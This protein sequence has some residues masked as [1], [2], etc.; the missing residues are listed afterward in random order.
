MGMLNQF[1]NAC[2]D[3]LLAPWSEASPWIGLTVASLLA[4]GVLVVL[5]HLS[6]DQQAL[7]RTR[8]RF[9]A[10]LLELLLF[11][12]DF[13]VNLSACGRIL[14]A[15][16]SYLGAMLRPMLLGAV[17]LM[18]LFI[19]LAC[20][21]EWRPLRIGET[22]VLEVELDKSHPVSQTVVDVSLPA[23]ARLDSPG[24]RTLAT[25]EQAWRVRGTGGGSGPIE[26]RVDGQTELKQLSVG[27]RLARLSPLR[28]QSSFWSDLL[29]PS[30]P[31]LAHAGPVSRIEITYPERQLLI[32]GD[33]IHWS[34]A[35]VVL[36]M[37][38][39][40]MLGRVFGVQVA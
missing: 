2:T 36:M 1:L 38:F 31:P 37:M 8:N 14:G 18:L 10:R 26:V 16:L 34:I 40:L 12:H 4:A 6:A 39:G 30:E 13:R 5:F 15:N 32:W 20:W 21:F 22:A 35:A 11:Q 28:A 19:Q 33:E 29:H 23:I 7:R 17:P 24:V 9:I 25:N 3:W 27:N